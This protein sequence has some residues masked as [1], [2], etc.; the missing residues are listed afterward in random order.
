MSSN[1]PDTERILAEAA[2]DLGVDLTAVS[3]KAAGPVRD[4]LKGWLDDDREVVD[5]KGSMRLM[6][7]GLTSQ[8]ERE[9]NGEIDS[10]LDGSQR[11]IVVRSIYR[12]LI[13]RVVE[14][15]PVNAPPKKG[16]NPI[17]GFRKRVKP[18]TEAELRGLAAGN[19]KRKSEAEA[20]RAARKEASG[21]RS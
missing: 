8:I 6:G 21:M 7:C 4:L 16:R 19:A 10:F 12:F 3:P 13:R 2:T 11:K 14:S 18:R 9:T 17:S 5:R 1:A 15:F 20:L